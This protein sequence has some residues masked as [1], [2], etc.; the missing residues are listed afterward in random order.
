MPERKTYKAADPVVMGA[1]HHSVDGLLF[2]AGSDSG[3]VVD[4]IPISKTKGE[5]RNG[6]DQHVGGRVIICH[7][8]I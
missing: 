1:G 7:F 2:V 8:E 4:V 6:S 3:G 5:V